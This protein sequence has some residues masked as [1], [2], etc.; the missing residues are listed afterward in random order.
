[1]PKILVVDDEPDLAL[2][3][4]QLLAWRGY[5][6]ATA[7]SGL[8]ALRAAERSEIGLVL[9]DWDLPQSPTGPVLVHKLR[10]VCGPSVPVIVLSA[11]RAALRAAL[12]VQVADY[13][14]RPFETPELVRLV[15]DYCVWGEPAHW[16]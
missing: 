16:S 8:G 5:D 9:L 11:E 4:A 3:I 2:A 15:E 1:M 14:P 10:E 12:A 6:V 13:L 7:Y